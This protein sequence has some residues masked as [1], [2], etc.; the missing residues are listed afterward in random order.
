MSGRK[1]RRSLKDKHRPLVTTPRSEKP[2]VTPP[3]KPK[4]PG[5]TLI[6]RQGSLP[7]IFKLKS[8][9]VT[10]PVSFWKQ[11]RHCLVWRNMFGLLR[12][13]NISQDSRGGSSS[14][15]ESIWFILLLFVL[16]FLPSLSNANQYCHLLGGECNYFLVYRVEK[17][18][19]IEVWIENGNS[20][21]NGFCFLF[22]SILRKLVLLVPWTGNET[23]NI[24]EQFRPKLV[25]KQWMFCNMAVLMSCST[26][27]IFYKP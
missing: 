15:E 4:I 1:K 5:K 6:W 2:S 14:T 13:L 22:Y 21:D 18:N 12:W 10:H 27:N 24:H 9:R 20:A 17:K 11:N 23:A 8:D 26:A 16:L 19:P 7:L 25:T 3:V